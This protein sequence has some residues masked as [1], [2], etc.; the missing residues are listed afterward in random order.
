MRQPEELQSN[1]PLR[2]SVGRGTDVWT[3]LVASA[4]GDYATVRQLLDDQP[5][6]VHAHYS[7]RTPL[8]F[9]VRENRSEI[10]FLLLD[11]GIDP[12]EMG[13]DD[14]LLE[15]C[16][17]RGHHQ[18][19]EALEARLAAGLN[20]SADGEALAAAIRGHDFLRLRELLDADPAAVSAGDARS[21]QPLH[22]AVMTRQPDMVD[23]LLSRG[24]D[25][26]APRVDGA[27][28]IQLCNGDYSFR[29]WSEVP[30]D[31]PTTARAMLDHLR[32]RGAFVDIVTAAHIG[33]LDRVR[34]LLR[35]DIG[36]ADK[37]SPYVSYYAGSGTPLANAAAA[38][39]LEIVRLLLASGA[40]P[41][42]PEPNIAPDGHALYAAVAN[43][44]RE[45]ARTLLEHGAFPNP[46]VES[47][48]DALTRAILNG[49]QPMADLLCAF[50]AY[51]KLHLL[52]HYGDVRTAAAMFAANPG[53]ADDA[54]A[55][56]SAAAEG[57]EPLVRLMLR[58][59]PDLPTRIA[60]P[61]G[62]NSA[63]SRML[64][65]LLY[66][67]GM[68]P[69]RPDWLGVTQL[70]RF[71]R[72]GDVENARLAIAYGADLSARDEDICSTPL[73]WAAKFGQLEMVEFL[74]DQGARSD[75][76]DAPVWATPIA[77]ASRRNHREIADVLARATQI[78]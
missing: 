1:A 13:G 51:R 12:T 69:N 62:W 39:H 21:N 48:A 19:R 63:T 46:E 55:L 42:L 33:D 35:E 70:H 47:S 31:W 43:R 53:L 78:S 25:I 27:R 28:P 73:G 22:W 52:A 58:Y 18:L 67:N 50:G 68:D 16:A 38:G 34:F 72:G 10:V 49:D 66:R 71:A 3:L 8:H 4:A 9:A 20:I 54:A 56:A 14:T 59:V 44:H 76:P 37:P 11:R 23:E 61:A 26:D 41:N 45:I 2:W 32:N 24:A 17:D 77:W 57:H 5:E 60:S 6:L 29:G 40:N 36:L 65:E 74:L 64:A 7:Y 15:V 75:E 30:N